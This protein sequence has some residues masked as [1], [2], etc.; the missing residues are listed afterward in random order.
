L[1]AAYIRSVTLH[2]GRAHIRTLIPDVLAL[3]ATGQFQPEVV[4][5]NVASFDDAPAAL[6]HHCSGNASKTILIAD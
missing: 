5:T 4:T 1:A 2:I 3:M 6:R